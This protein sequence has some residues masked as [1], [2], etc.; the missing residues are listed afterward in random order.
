MILYFD[1]D[2]FIVLLIQNNEKS[3][4]AWLGLED[5]RGDPTM[6]LLV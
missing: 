3:G 6:L 2:F 1:K 5:Q 4:F